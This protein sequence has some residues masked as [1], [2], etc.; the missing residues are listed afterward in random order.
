[1]RLVQGVQVERR[2]GLA[3]PMWTTR[4]RNSRCRA[5][6]VL[7]T[8]RIRSR[9]TVRC[10][11][12]SQPLRISTRSGVTRYRVVTQ[13]RKSPNALSTPAQDPIDQ[14]PERAV[15]VEDHRAE[16]AEDEREQQPDQIHVDDPDAEPLPLGASVMW[17]RPWSP[18]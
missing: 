8:L 3:D 10:F 18:R 6:A 16:I 4:S 13:R 1:M 9:R 15:V 11:L 14:R 7:S 5:F 17:R 2:I 12:T